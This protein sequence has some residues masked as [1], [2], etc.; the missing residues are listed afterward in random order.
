MLL[1]S[2]GRAR[3]LLTLRSQK[4]L[5]VSPTQPTSQE[6]SL[7]SQGNGGAL[8]RN[9]EPSLDS[10]VEIAPRS[11]VF[12]SSKINYLPSLTSQFYEASNKL[13]SARFEDN[14][15]FKSVPPGGT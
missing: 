12:D 14:E 9:K 13:N 11:K 10:S 15:D 2:N 1:W 8:L 5:L 7:V 3:P 6:N 4:D